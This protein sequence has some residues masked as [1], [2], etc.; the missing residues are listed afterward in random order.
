VLLNGHAQRSKR[1]SEQ[2]C[3]SNSLSAS[4]EVQRELSQLRCFRRPHHGC[5]GISA[6]WLHTLNNLL[7]VLSAC[8]LF[9]GSAAA[10]QP[11]RPA[12]LCMDMRRLACSWWTPECMHWPA[13][14]VLSMHLLQPG[15]RCGRLCCG[16]TC[17]AQ[18]RQHR[19]RPQAT[20][21]CR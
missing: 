20:S 21:R 15:S 11:L 6:A 1:L 10:R 2:G 16:W 19:W 18:R 8:F 9:T 13:S 5:C 4:A 3:R 7:A 17:A 14:F 12:L